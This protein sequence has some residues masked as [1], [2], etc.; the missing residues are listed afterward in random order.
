MTTNIKKSTPLH[1]RQTTVRTL[2][3]ILLVTLLSASRIYFA[4]PL[5][6]VNDKEGWLASRS[7]IQKITT[8][9]QTPPPVSPPPSHPPSTTAAN[10]LPAQQHEVNKAPLAKFAFGITVVPR[11]TP[12][13]RPVA[14]YHELF[15]ALPSGVPIIVLS[16]MPEV[17]THPKIT[18][19][20]HY[21]VNST[22]SEFN[23]TLLGRPLKL[24]H[25]DPLP[26]VKWRS[27]LVLDFITAMNVSSQ[28]GRYPVWLE[29]DVM[30]NEWWFED[31]N[32]LVD[33]SEHVNWVFYHLH[34]TGTVGVVMNPRFLAEFLDFIYARF[35]EDP[36]D[37]IMD[38]AMSD[39]T[40]RVAGEHKLYH[41]HRHDFV[42]HRG[43]VGSF[44]GATRQ[45]H[46]PR[47]VSVG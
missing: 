11:K 21:G 5:G 20:I 15:D 22:R 47:R 41:S 28:Y 24:N 2:L 33:R 34:V 7:R 29:D 25:G 46:I 27:S 10:T 38:K 39:G 23:E 6:P 42:G 37:W 3:L 16:R 32:K 8:W 1:A 43:V 13:G 30:L 4:T 26:H 35:D 19:S 36:L 9:A 44:N 14:Y 18:K 17:I 31:L 12:E 40:F 45:V